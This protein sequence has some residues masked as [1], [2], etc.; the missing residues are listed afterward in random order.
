MFEAIGFLT[1]LAI[2]VYLIA[3]HTTKPT[4]EEETRIKVR[5]EKKAKELIEEESKTLFIIK[6]K[7][8]LFT[9]FKNKTIT[10]TELKNKL[11][12]TYNYSDDDIYKIIDK[13]RDYSLIFY[14]DGENLRM[15]Y[16]LEKEK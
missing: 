11:N 10:R 2:I 12:S 6:Y 14:I 3:Q 13:M 4:K 5:N 9:L 15:G 7:D 8:F 1:V 16:S